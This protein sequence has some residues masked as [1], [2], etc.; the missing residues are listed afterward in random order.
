MPTTAIPPIL[1]VIL[2]S[3]GFTAKTSLTEGLQLT[4]NWYLANCRALGGA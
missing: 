1:S 2:A 4:Y 3:L